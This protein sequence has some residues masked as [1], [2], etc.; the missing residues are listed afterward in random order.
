[1]AVRRDGR[2]RGEQFLNVI[3]IVRPGLFTT[4]Q[5]PG[6]TGFSR[7]GVP[8]SGAADSHS[9]RLANWLAG[10]VAS[11]AVLEVTL[12]AAEFSVLAPCP[13]GIAGARAAISVNG[14]SVDRGRAL[15]LERGDRVVIGPA[16]AGLRVYVAIGGGIDVPLVMGSRAT[17]SAS[18]LGGFKG[19]KLAAGD[20]LPAGPRTP[21]EPRVLSP[22]SEALVLR[23]EA[24]VVGGP[25]LD[26]F[27]DAVRAAFF[28]GTFRVSSRS[29]RRGLRLEGAPVPPTRGDIDPEGV[30]VGAIQVPA[31]GE[32]IVLMPD[33][34]VTGGYPKIA[35]VIRAD[36]PVLGQWRP[37]QAVRFREITLAAA[38]AAWK[39]SEE[40]WRE[41]DAA[42]KSI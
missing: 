18:G 2:V 9:A 26:F 16:E 28:G 5:D 11:A 3:E 20:V 4:V 25:Q 6:R 8:V 32:P 36:L 22:S 30:V 21:F 39:E 37:G 40:A 13:I 14:A 1:M 35:A 19:R 15:L 23:D 27:P 33:G 38:I 34:P 12:G 31:G 29:D 7:W 17:L 10:N 42:A 24:R 41:R